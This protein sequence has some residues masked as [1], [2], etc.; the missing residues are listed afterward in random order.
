ML[1]IILLLLS[2]GVGIF[3]MLSILAIAKWI[4][5]FILVDLTLWIMSGLLSIRRVF[6][7]PQSGEQE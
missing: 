2:L 7:K 6:M 4:A 1:T 5:L 3:S